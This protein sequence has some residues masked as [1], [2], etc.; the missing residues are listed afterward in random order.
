VVSTLRL[1]SKVARVIRVVGVPSLSS[2][3]TSS[4]A[5]GEPRWNLQYRIRLLSRSTSARRLMDACLEKSL[6][7]LGDAASWDPQL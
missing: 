4:K 3:Y 2:S 7:R 5:P 1:E 6:M